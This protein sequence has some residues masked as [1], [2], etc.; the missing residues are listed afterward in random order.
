M[1][2]ATYSQISLLPGK[3][4]RD[5]FILFPGKKTEEN[6]RNRGDLRNRA[7]VSVT[8]GEDAKESFFNL[9]LILHLLNRSGFH[10]SSWVMCYHD[11]VWP[12]LGEKAK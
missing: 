1:G 8:E 3:R 2:A 12:F 6:V 10:N 9:C 7:S 11:K 5:T 4:K